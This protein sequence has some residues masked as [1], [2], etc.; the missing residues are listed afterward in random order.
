MGRTLWVV[1]VLIFEAG[2]HPTADNTAGVEDSPYDSMTAVGC[3]VVSV[4]GGST[5]TREKK[6]ASGGSNV[7]RCERVRA[8]LLCDY[9]SLE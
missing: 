6:A 5:T 9:R 3:P 4:C 2:L 8:M 7:G 1:M